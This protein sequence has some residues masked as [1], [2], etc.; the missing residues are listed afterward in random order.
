MWFAMSAYLPNGMPT[1][2]AS[3]TPSVFQANATTSSTFSGQPGTPY[4]ATW[5][6][7]TYD[8]P[9]NSNTGNVTVYFNGTW[10]V[11]NIYPSSFVPIGEGQDFLTI[12]DTKGY[13]SV[14]VQFVEPSSLIGTTTYQTISYSAPPGVNIPFNSMVNNISYVPYSS[15]TVTTLTSTS[16]FAAIPYGSTVSITTYNPWDQAVGSVSNYLVTN[17]SGMIVVPL[18]V[19]EISF[20]FYNSSEQYVYLSANGYNLSYFGNAVVLNNS[21][22]HWSTSY[23]SLT[24]GE[25]QYVTGSV[26]VT[27]PQ[28]SVAIYLNAPPGQLQVNV[29][30]YS[31][32]NLGSISSGG[33]PRILA[34]IDGKPYTTGSTFS[35]FQGSTYA[36]RIADL[37][38]QTLYAGNITLSGSFT[39]VTE[40]IATPRPP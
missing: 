16:S 37:L 21:L 15:S 11:A 5:Q 23:F 31:G 28:Q 20:V 3:S 17:Q 40:A 19:S 26:Q 39:S 27:Q 8:V 25:K 12:T 10:T 29:N 38:N 2:T 18:K 7:F 30:A 36:I 9:I 13:S 1:F 32:S 34:F 22:Y 35:G 14:Q 24:S 4:N 6:Y 33:N